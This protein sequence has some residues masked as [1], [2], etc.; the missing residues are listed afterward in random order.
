MGGCLLEYFW[1][2]G[3]KHLV[4]VLIKQMRYKAL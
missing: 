2:S 4:Y 1:A 3:P